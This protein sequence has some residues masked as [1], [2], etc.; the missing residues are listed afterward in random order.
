MNSKSRC[1]GNAGS[2][3]AVRGFRTLSEERC[4]RGYDRCVQTLLP[5]VVA[6]ETH[7]NDR[8]YSLRELKL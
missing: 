3:L 1:Q 7:W 4:G 5:D 2:P 8:S 6:P